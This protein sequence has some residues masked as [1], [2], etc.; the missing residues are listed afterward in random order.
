MSRNL[1]KAQF[2]G[3]TQESLPG[4]KSPEHYPINNLI[5]ALLSILSL[6]SGGASYAHEFGIP[7]PH[8]ASPQWKRN[9]VT[10]HSERSPK[11]MRGFGSPIA[12]ISRYVVSRHGWQRASLAARSGI[13][14][15]ICFPSIFSHVQF[16]Q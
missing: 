11:T 5:S 13:K 3:R 14:P 9:R 2:P 15:C 4:G 1:T 8:E 12:S 16:L 7:P 10:R 6:S